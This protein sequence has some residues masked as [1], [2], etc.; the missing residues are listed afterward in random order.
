MVFEDI[1]ERKRAAEARYRRLFESARD[2]ILLVDSATGEILDLNPFAERLLGYRR[3]ERGW[4]QALGDRADAASAQA[5]R[6]RRTDSGPGRHAVRRRS[7]AYREG[8]DVPVEMIASVYSEGERRGI[9]FNLRDITER[10]SFQRELQE[11][12]KLESLGRAGGRHRA[13]L[14]Q[15]ADRHPGQR[16]PGVFGDRP[17]APSRVRLLGRSSRPGSAPRSSP[18]RCWRMRARGALVR[19]RIDLGGFVQEISPL[20]R[21][22]I[23]NSVDLKL[24]LAPDLPPIEA[25]SARIQQALLNLVINGAEAIGEDTP[26]TVTLRTSVR[27]INERDA[28]DWFQGDQSAPGSYVQ[29]E[30]ADT[31]QGMEETTKSRIFNPFFTTKSTG[32][33]LG[34]AAVEGIVRGHHGAIRV[35]STPGQGSTFLILLPAAGRDHAVDRSAAPRNP[36]IP[37][38]SVALVIEDDKIVRTL[39]EGVLTNAGMKV[40]PAENGRAGVELFREHHRGIAVVIVGMQIPSIEAD[41]TIGS[42]KQINP[43]VPVI[44]SSGLD[45]REASR[46][47]ARQGAAGYLQKPYTSERL[48][49]TVAGALGRAQK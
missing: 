31:G 19:S 47:L 23:P 9:Q 46:S 1:T 11:T 41:E 45:E 22:S 18:A 37:P 48:V 5:P 30:V 43:G 36:A 38:G 10:K 17:N 34:L 27:E 35:Y 24:D 44:L 6:R 25:D 28:A 8:R 20:L 26:G 13:R 12:Q 7:V 42:M 32:R 21:T 16:Q 3:D 4:Q 14:Q 49:D 15:P 2:G 39:V 29:L 33:G 40:L